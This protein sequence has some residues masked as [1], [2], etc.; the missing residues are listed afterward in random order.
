ME[1]KKN[2]RNGSKRVLYELVQ[3]LEDLLNIES[4]GIEAIASTYFGD[5]Y[6]ESSDT[7]SESQDFEP[8]KEVYPTME[9]G[10][11]FVFAE[12]SELDF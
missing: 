6:V 12:D 11:T 4:T 8:F 5:A 10:H 2:S 3:G 7:D 9:V 1:K